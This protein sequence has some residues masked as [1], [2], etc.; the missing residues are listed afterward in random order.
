MSDGVRA[1]IRL[2]MALLAAE[3]RHDRTAVEH[4]LD[5]EFVEVGASGRRWT[6]AETIAALGA[7]PADDHGE[8]WATDLVGTELAA[9]VVLLTYV[10]QRG[11]HRAR[12]ASMWRRSNGSWRIVYHQGTPCDA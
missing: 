5:P 8:P 10:S 2:E 12:R 1:V 7:D 6:R 11:P 4:L 9:G 3:T